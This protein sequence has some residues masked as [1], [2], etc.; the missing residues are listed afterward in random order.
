MFDKQ[1]SIRWRYRR[2]HFT[3]I[4][5]SFSILSFFRRLF[6][7]FLVH[8]SMLAFFCLAFRTTLPSFVGKQLP[9]QSSLSIQSSMYLSFRI[10]NMNWNSKNKLKLIPLE[11]YPIDVDSFVRFDKKKKSSLAT[12]AEQSTKE[13]MSESGGTGKK[14]KSKF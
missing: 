13:W 2:S 9:F 10:V 4:F 11:F 14:S 6:A 5:V 3:I 8:S 12:A 1:Y 7:S